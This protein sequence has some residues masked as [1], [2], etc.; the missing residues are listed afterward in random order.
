[1]DKSK[2]KNKCRYVVLAVDK[3]DKIYTCNGTGEESVAFILSLRKLSARSVLCCA[4]VI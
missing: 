3:K 4:L 2:K 1:M